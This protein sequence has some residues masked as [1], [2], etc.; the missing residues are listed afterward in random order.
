MNWLVEKC[1]ESNTFAWILTG[2]G[3]A[4]MIIIALI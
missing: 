2:I 3:I 1:R 4:V